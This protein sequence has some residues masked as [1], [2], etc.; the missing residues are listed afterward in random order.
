MPWAPDYITPQQLADYLRVDDQVDDDELTDAVAGASRAVDR[1]TFR[2]FGTTDGPEARVFKATWSYSRGAWVVECDDFHVI[3]TAIVVDTARDGSYSGVVDPATY[4]VPL[5][6]NAAQTGR[7]W[8]RLVLR[9]GSGVTLYGTDGEV[10]VTTTWGWSEVPSTVMTA[11]KLQASRL[12]A[13]RSA[14]FGIA[15]SPDSGSELRLL[16]RVDPD[17]AVM[18]GD[19]RRRG[20]G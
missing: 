12:H 4:A 3:P 13:R 1:A 11:T 10:R 19:Y 15:G 2:Q 6:A 7:P 17:V 16:A 8:E 18:L 20:V 14:P 9:S 5:P